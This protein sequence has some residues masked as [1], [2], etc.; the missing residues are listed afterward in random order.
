MGICNALK[1][2]LATKSDEIPE[3]CRK[4]GE[5]GGVIF[6]PKIYVVDFGNFKK[7]FHEF[8]TK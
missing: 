2:R 4:E 6:N 7:G 8:D 1:G 5:G 3:K